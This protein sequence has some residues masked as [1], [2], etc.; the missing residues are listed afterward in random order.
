[1]NRSTRAFAL[2]LIASATAAAQPAP[3]SPPPP[4]VEPVPPIDPVA[5]VEP[6]P[7]P[8]QPPMPPQPPPPPSEA[9]ATETSSTRPEGLAFGIGLGYVLPTS[10]QTPN[11]TSVRMRLAS[12]LTIEPALTVANAK[13]STDSGLLDSED[14]ITEF[15]VAATVRIPTMR[16]GKVELEILGSAGFGSVKNNP[17][18]ADNDT[19]RATLGLRWGLAVS[20]WLTRHWNLSLSATNPLV[21][22]SKSTREQLAPEPEITETTTAIGVTFDPVVSVMIHLYN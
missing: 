17:D 6:P 10:V 12:G 1:M 20:Y 4:P 11:I 21:S 13:T 3:P 8:A 19:T 15:G 7:P 22:F 16:H 18:G 9:S 14:K 2:L 5:P